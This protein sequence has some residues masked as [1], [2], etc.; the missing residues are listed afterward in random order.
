MCFLCQ[1][2]IEKAFKALLLK[3]TGE[4]RK[5][6][7]LVILGKNLMPRKILLVMLKN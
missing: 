5:T 4:I 7:D 2:A 6:H 1:Q 3:R